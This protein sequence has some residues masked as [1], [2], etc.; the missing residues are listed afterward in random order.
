MQI[1]KIK[2]IIVF[3]VIAAC[4]GGGGYYY[5]NTGKPVS[6]AVTQTTVVERGKITSSVSATGTI[7]PVNSVDI[8][9]KVTA[10][11]KQV[12][13]KENDTVKAGQ[14]V[15]TLDS[16]T[17]QT[18]LEQAKYKVTNT[19]AKY[20]RLQYLNSIGAKSDQDLEDALLDYQTA[21]STYE[22]DQAN[23]NDTIIVSP[24]DGVVIGEPKTVGTMVTAGVTSPTVIMTVADMSTKQIN[25]KVDETDIGKVK[26]G[27]KA[28]FTVDAYTG[29]TFTATVSNISQTD[30]S[31]TWSSSTST[32]TVIYYSV[33]LDIDDP[34]NL[35]KPAMTARVNINIAEKNDVLMIP[36]SALKTNN[37]GQYVV[38]VT[39]DGKTENRNVTVGLYSDDKVEILDGLSEGDKLSISYTKSTSKSSTSS[40]QG[41]PPM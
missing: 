41:G 39:P 19:E 26:V 18:T 1:K 4:I 31:S 29:K 25:A 21:V 15:A 8:S 38:V 33:T 6:S 9:S 23:V 40:K 7:K 30:V 17:L 12:M 10:R 11:L 2:W 32:T 34:E 28:N 14:T 36:L 20:K 24:M 37:D 35:L 13:F 5:Y 22:G 3:V 16:T 27:Q